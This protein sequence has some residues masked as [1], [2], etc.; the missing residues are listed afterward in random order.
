M[1]P[2]V[3]ICLKTIFVNTYTHL[4]QCKS[5]FLMHKSPMSWK[6]FKSVTVRNKSVQSNVSVGQI[7]ISL[8]CWNANVSKSLEIKTGSEQNENSL[9]I[10]YFKRRPSMSTHY[11]ETAFKKTILLLFSLMK[12]F[13]MLLIYHEKFELKI[14]T[15]F[16]F[17]K[18]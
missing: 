18:S 9:K 8:Y 6:C 1:A 13:R 15:E 4:K 16:V 7:L 14:R 17:M 12:K 5:Y 10:I 3:I 11:A 2:C